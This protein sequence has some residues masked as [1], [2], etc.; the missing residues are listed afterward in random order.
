MVL[1]DRPSEHGLIWKSAADDTDSD[2]TLYHGGAG[3]VLEAHDHF[4]DDR[5]AEAALRGARDIAAQVERERFWSL[6][7]GL[8]GMAVALRAVHIRLD[9][10][11]CERAARR[12]LA[13]HR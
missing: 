7:S 1:S 5:Y 6:Y 12:G 8:T 13:H 10:P 9:D 3:I 2:P 11:V 4:G